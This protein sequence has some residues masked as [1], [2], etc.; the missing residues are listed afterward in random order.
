MSSQT[1]P[2]CGW[3]NR[4][5][6]R[7]CSNCGASMVPSADG[8]STG[9]TAQPLSA[10]TAVSDLASS[11]ET[12]AATNAGSGSASSASDAT[13]PVTYVVQRWNAPMPN[14]EVPS[15][16]ATTPSGFVPPAPPSQASTVPIA[17]PPVP[18]YSSYGAD[19][20]AFGTGA[21]STAAS[22]TQSDSNRTTGGTYVP[23]STDAAQQLQ[24]GAP[25][26]SWLVPAIVVGAIALLVLVGVSGFL[27]LNGKQG[28]PSS[29]AGT[30][31]PTAASGSSAVTGCSGLAGATGS[32]DEKT[33]LKAIICQSNDEQIKAWRN[34]D[35][36]IL[37]GTRTGQA[38]QENIQ[39]VQELQ[40]KKMYALPANKSIEFGDVSVTG[41]TAT[42][43][44]VEVWSVTFFNKDDGQALQ[45]QGPDT[46]QELYHFVKQNGKWLIQSV[47]IVQT[48]VP[49]A[50]TP[51]SLPGSNNA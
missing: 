47:D 30:T 6:N 18:P 19:T 25:K 23:Y 51:T 22:T 9:E 31:T 3:L 12:G 8:P 24:G 11:A 26:R 2:N 20:S 7:F 40:A 27:I 45:T 46:L 13:Q 42:V 15:E 50:P 29:V 17:P 35:T 1:C 32:S 34:L 10:P 38:L 36:E 5:T 16:A 14:V 48:N 44:T 33:A 43:K 4:A 21:A 49:N 28:S 41:N 39:A 37:K